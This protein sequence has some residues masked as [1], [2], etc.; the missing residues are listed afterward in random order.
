MCLK[1]R[2]SLH[3][4]EMEEAGSLCK[5]CADSPA[6]DCSTNYQVSGDMITSSLFKCNVYFTVCV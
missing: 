5:K 6:E 1:K 3:V 2:A 4:V